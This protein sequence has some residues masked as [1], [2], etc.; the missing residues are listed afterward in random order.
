MPKIGTMLLLLV[1]LGCGDDAVARVDTG[2]VD[3]GAPRTDAGA[4]RTDAGRD[5]QT[6]RPDA[7]APDAGV[8]AGRPDAGFD[9]GPPDAGF[10]AGPAGPDAGPVIHH[11]WR[12][13]AYPEAACLGLAE[14]ACAACHFREGVWYLLPRGVPPPP[15][16]IP[17]APY[18]ECGVAPP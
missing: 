18:D 11:D 10:D 6:A 12:P 7:G 5:A 14:P 13:L 2:R 16:D 1:S 4:P 9:A 8:D 17:P 15:P 3:A